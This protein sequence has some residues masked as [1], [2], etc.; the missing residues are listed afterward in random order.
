MRPVGAGALLA[1]LA[2]LAAPAQA[3]DYGAFSR[4]LGD[5][6]GDGKDDVLLRRD[7]GHW[8]FYAMDG[9]RYRPGEQGPANLTRNLDY[10]V[11]GIGDFDGDGKAD[12]LMRHVYDGRW[13]FY[14]MDG[15]R[16]IPGRQGGANLTAD[17]R[18]GVAG[19][20]DFNGDGRDDVLLRRDDGHWYYYP[21]DGRRYIAG[22][23]GAANL[24]R[25]P[26]YAVAGIG[27]FD[28]DGKDDVLMRHIDG[29]WYH[30]AMDGRR[31]I[32]GRQG[33]ANLTRNLAYRI[34]AIGDFDGD[35]K[36]DVLIRRADGHWYHYAMAGRRYRPGTQGA[37]GLT[38]NLA[39][40]VAG[41]GDL[42]GDGNDDVLM[43]SSRGAWYF[44]PMQGRRYIRGRQ[45]HAN[46][47]TRLVWTPASP[48]LGPAPNE[49]PMVATIADRS[50]AVGEALT[51]EVSI[52]DAN[53]GDSHALGAESRDGCVAEAS[54]D[55]TQLTITG[56]VAGEAAIAVT[57]TDSRGAESETITFRV[58]VEPPDR[59]SWALPRATPAAAETTPCAVDGVVSEVFTD[60]AMQSA[61]LLVDGRV[62]GERYAPGYDHGSLGTSWSV[63][64]SFYSAAIGVAIDEGHIESLNQR[65]SDFLTEWQ[66]TNKA[67]ITIRQILEMRSGLGNGNIFEVADQTQFA[68][69]QG[70]VAI[71]GYRFIYSNPNSQLFEPLLRRAT[72]FDAHDWLTREVLEPIGIDPSAVGFWLDPTGTQPL[73]YCCLDMRPDDFGRFG[74]LY[75]NDGAWEGA[76]VVS[77]GYVEASLTAQSDFYGFQW[78]VMNSSYYRGAAPPVDAVAAHGLDGQH[79]YLWR[80]A[81]V[82]LVVLTRYIHDPDDGY[83]LSRDNWPNTCAARNTCWA[84]SGDEVPAYNEYRVMQRLAE[85]RP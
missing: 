7:D 77:D 8:Y 21:M 82:V 26:D 65:A 81:N 66:G 61:L 85:L 24:T 52:E 39:Y 50:I 9:R 53:P 80:D 14:A 64:K 43:R 33:I 67:N 25:N 20:G 78:W 48:I 72:G 17:L 73:T 83:V 44:Y 56:R 51:L 29:R 3:E 47:S 30:Y 68:L 19:I 74:L 76:Q 42:D 46:L 84:S 36:H 54:V 28:G 34:A 63:A 45:G 69:D 57:A 62:V 59:P 70:R 27:D 6:N 10:R 79:I 31:Y 35:G 22:E 13:Y 16:Y 15:R 49:A 2:G 38:R 23:Q 71:P 11:A 41:V 12:V 55:G 5:F 1:L 40:E 75:L 18:Y 4:H 58:T 32:P 37:A 60:R